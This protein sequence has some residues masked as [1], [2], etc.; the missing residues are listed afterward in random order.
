[1][2]SFVVCNWNSKDYVWRC[3]E[4]IHAQSSPD[5]ELIVVDNDSTNG[6]LERMR[7]L[8]AAG[9][10][11]RLIELGTN[12]G[13]A[14]GMNAGA[15]VARGEYV[16]PLNSD[17]YLARNFVEAV[18]TFGAAAIAVDPQ[19]G[20]IATPVYCWKWDGTRDELTDELSSVGVT[21]VRRLTYSTW[22]PDIDPADT[23]F[24]AEGCAPVLT[25]AAVDAAMRLAGQLFDHSYFAYAEDI[26]LA[27]RLHTLGFRCAPC[28]DTAVWHIGSASSDG[29]LSFRDKPIELQRLAHRNR[30]R[31]L[32]RIP[33]GAKYLSMLP[34][35][36]VEDVAR[37]AHS[38]HPVRLLAAFTRN[39]GDALR[40][41]EPTYPRSDFR[42]AGN[43]FSPSWTHRRRGG[44]LPP[45]RVLP[46]ALRAP[47]EG[48]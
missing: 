22:H 33:L 28:M 31:N 44:A 39:Y 13:Y 46:A 35:M 43:V 12:V 20:I 9:V 32:A 10:V 30:L 7:E 4:S 42:F 18:Q 26:D 11:H 5:W 6:S 16:V 41:T 36:L 15:A 8:A 40:G 45:M 34:L 14:G 19:V 27:I 21:L 37:L 17:V 48:K 25:R 24:S 3:I 38:A 23:L 2:I 29:R 1:V 47:L